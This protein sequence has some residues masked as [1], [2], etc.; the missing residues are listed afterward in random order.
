MAEDNPEL[1]FITESP[2]INSLHEGT[3][4]LGKHMF[5][6]VNLISRSVKFCL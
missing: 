3:A 1:F 5:A 4:G 6:F 2:D